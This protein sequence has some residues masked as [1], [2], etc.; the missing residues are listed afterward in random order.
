MPR[1]H[2]RLGWISGCLLLL[3]PVG[4]LAMTGCSGLQ[5]APGA[6]AAGDL[7]SPTHEKDALREGE[8]ERGEEAGRR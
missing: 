2:R 3:A 5:P 7:Q 1:Q 6:E 4:G 8:E